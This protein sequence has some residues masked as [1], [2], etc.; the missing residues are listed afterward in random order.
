M[1]LAAAAAIPPGFVH[2]VEGDRPVAQVNWPADAVPRLIEARWPEMLDRFGLAPGLNL[3]GELRSAFEAPPADDRLAGAPSA[4]PA[5]AEP[6][7]F[8]RVGAAA[9]ATLNAGLLIASLAAA[10]L[11]LHRRRKALGLLML[12]AVPVGLLAADA[13]GESLRLALLPLQ[14]LLL[15]V[16]W[17]PARR[18]LPPS[19]AFREPTR[20]AGFT[21]GQNT[22]RVL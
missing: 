20:D 9:W 16:F 22:P 21:I 3:V 17:L 2:L 1:V 19:K 11:A 6:S 8:D 10:T 12:S 13:S 4:A 5:D 15:G 18:F 14:L 7:G